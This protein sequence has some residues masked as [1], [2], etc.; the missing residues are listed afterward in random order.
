[1]KRKTKIL[2]LLLV[3][4]LLAVA[5]EVIET[6]GANGL[7]EKNWNF[8]RIKEWSNFACIKENSAELV[9][10]L[11]EK[12]YPKLNHLIALSGGKIVKTISEILAIVVDIPFDS[13]PNFVEKAK[14]LA[15]YIEPNLKFRV[16]SVPNDPYWNYQWGPKKIKAD[17]AWNATF[18][19]PSILVAVVDTGIDYNHSDLAANYV[20]LGYDWAYN[21]TD[22]MD[23]WN[24]GT[25]VAGIIAAVT[26]NEIG[27]AGLAQVKI[28]AEKVFNK[29]GVGYESWI[30][31]AILHATD[32]GAKII[33]LSFSIEYNGS[34]LY[35]AVKYAYQNNVLLV[36]AAGNEANDTKVYPAAYDEVIAVTATDSNDKPAYFTNFG[37]WVELAAP[38]VNIYSTLLW[39][40]YDYWSG[41]SFA[42][43]HVSGLAALIW[44]KFPNATRDWVRNRLRE[45]ADDLGDPGFD[46][47]YGY[48]RINAEKAIYGIEPINYT[49]TILT[50]DGGTTDPQPGNYTYPEGKNVSVNAIA[51]P[52]YKFDYWEIN[53]INSGATNPIN[54]T[55]NANYTLK[56]VFRVLIHDI[57]IVR[58]TSPAIIDQGSNLSINVTIENQGDFKETFNLTLY[59]NTTPIEIKTIS[60]ESGSLT[61]LDFVWNTTGFA[62]GKYILS[63]QIEPVLEEVDISDN[64]KSIPLE[65]V[66]ISFEGPFYWGS[67]EYWVVQFGRERRAVRLVSNY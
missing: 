42:C 43:P 8:E 1:M 15:R 10:G 14:G 65:I 21:D 53:T 64:K 37:N 32:R 60:L 33:N 41:T 25:F 2:S 59:L 12:E 49:L 20:A 67:I 45:T 50:T 52:G 66:T 34:L 47:Y 56:A 11:K 22:P 16:E 17:W 61:T 27:I 29:E 24:H 35:E 57:A 5:T 23:D 39:N 4:I 9:I 46:I 63:A 40:R 30:A 19:D 48:G 31:S 38:G 28:M 36:A 18:G 58:I 13:I 62:E 54:L 6:N 55:M 7:N 3:A 26:N 44:S 51:D